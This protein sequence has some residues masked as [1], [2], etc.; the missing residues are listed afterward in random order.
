MGSV[1]PFS[2]GGLSASLAYLYS[3]K[4]FFFC[5]L[6]I[7]IEFCFFII[8]LEILFV[9]YVLFIIAIRK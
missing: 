6:F 9:Y 4:F 5:N 2:D 1:G 7:A 3:L 8:K